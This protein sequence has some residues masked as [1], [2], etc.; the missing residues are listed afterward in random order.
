MTFEGGESALRSFVRA[1]LET[2]SFNSYCA[3]KS[4]KEY[5]LIAVSGMIL[6]TFSPLPVGGVSS[7]ST[8][9]IGLGRKDSE[10]RRHKA[11]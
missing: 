5:T 11:Q 6:I 1:K 3:G 9:Q 10:L 2:V 7:A 8:A 4:M